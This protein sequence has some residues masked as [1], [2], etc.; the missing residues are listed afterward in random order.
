ME[1]TSSRRRGLRAFLI[2]AG[3]ALSAAAAW[4]IHG[5]WVRDRVTTDNA[6]V[7]AD[8]VPLAAR[9]AGTVVEVPVHDN[10][11]VHAGAVLVQ[12]DRRD[13]EVRLRQAEADLE[14]A[15]AEADAAGAQVPVT[16]AS[17]EGGLSSAQAQLAGS[18]AGARTAAAQVEVEQGAL[19]RAQAQLD[20][21]RADRD[22]ARALRAEDAIAATAL[23][24]AEAAFDAARADVSAAQ[25][26]LQAAREQRGLAES[27][28]AEARARVEQSGPVAE[29]VAAASARARLAQARAAAA[30]A[31][32]DQ[33]RLQLSYTTVVAP[34]DGTVSRLAVHPGQ[35]VQ[36]GS[37]LL[38]VVPTEA[39]V[40]ANLK[41]TEV[42]GVHAGE[43]VEIRVDALPG[44]VLHGHVESV[45]AGTGARFSLLPP[46]NATGN[47]VKV[48]QRVPV[49]IALDEPH[50]LRAG[51]SAEVTIHTGS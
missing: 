15:R 30:E 34:V 36:P 3:V 6:Q 29:Q 51:L 1:T 49:R 33:A 11:R 44:E 27:R 47:F 46:D 4:L 19:A 12:I 21:A 39:Y 18:S 14:A 2:L 26:R 7:E 22:R 24:S 8:V 10:Q 38:A 13:L 41:E 20:K 28:V 17:S 25:A 37:T 48:V 32:R 23:E 9:V 16:Q 40:V 50:D 42:A 45:S 31:A 43:P 35:A 5:W